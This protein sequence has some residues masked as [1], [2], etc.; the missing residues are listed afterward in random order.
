MFDVW[1]SEVYLKIEVFG[2][3]VLFY[4]VIDLCV[5]VVCKGGNKVIM[6]GDLDGVKFCVFG[7]VM[8]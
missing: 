8:L 2:F 6:L 4:V 1:K 3:K 5:V 7:L